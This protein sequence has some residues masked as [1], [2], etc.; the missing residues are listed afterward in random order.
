MRG[1]RAVLVAVESCGDGLLRHSTVDLAAAEASVRGLP[2]R[3]VCVGAPAA[4]PMEGAS[5]ADAELL[6]REARRRFAEAYPDLPVSAVVIEGDPAAVVIGEAARAELVV[7]GRRRR[8]DLARCVE[9]EIAGSVD[10]PVIVAS[11]AQHPVAPRASGGPVVV[12]MKGD[13]RDAAAVVFG[14]EEAALRDVALQ[15]VHVWSNI[16]DMDLASVD[17]FVYDLAEARRDAERLIEAGLDGWA[18][19]YPEVRV[20][21]IPLYQLDVAATLSE[22]SAEA[23]L[24]VLGHR[25]DGSGRRLLGRVTRSLIDESRCPIAVAR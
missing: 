20:E 5:P 8:A 21:R 23:S 1:S 15:L 17:P 14:L 6:V 22:A 3:L 4:Y 11:G 7:V 9:A 16:P 12:G 19:K 2:L 18:Q 25:R 10:C 13:D 24:L